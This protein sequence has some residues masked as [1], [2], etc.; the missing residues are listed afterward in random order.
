MDPSA[1][2]ALAASE[3]SLFRSF[4]LEAAEENE[5]PNN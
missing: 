2:A 5:Q 1:H 4:P 3:G